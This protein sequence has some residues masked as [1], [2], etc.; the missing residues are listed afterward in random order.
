MKRVIPLFSFALFL[1][2]L[3]S[4]AFATS[5]VSTSPTAGSVLSISPT[6]VSIKASAD[7]QD[8][9]NEITV[10]DST[11]ARVDD[12][13]IQIQGSVLLVGIKP[14]KLSGLYT[15]SYSM[16][17][18]DQPPIVGTFTFLYNAPAEMTLPTPAPTQEAV[19]SQSPNRITDILVL[20]LMIFAFIILVLLSRY[21]KQT[22]RTP[23]KAKPVGKKNSSSKKFLK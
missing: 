19:L 11:G 8:G 9:A 22:F 1:I 6:A 16:M 7:L 21:A 17:S 4:S 15:V 10:T 5:I 23:A 2:S 3:T 18:I 13:A 12:G 20:G 14:L